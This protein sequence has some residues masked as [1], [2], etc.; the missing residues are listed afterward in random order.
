MSQLFSG[1][2][3]L[4]NTYLRI[5]TL[6]LKGV[7]R[8]VFLVRFGVPRERWHR[9]GNN[10]GYGEEHHRELALQFSHLPTSIWAQWP[11][12]SGPRNRKHSEIEAVTRSLGSKCLGGA[13]EPHACLVDDTLQENRGLT[14]ASPDSPTYLSYFVPKS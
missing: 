10:E 11:R 6:A 14:Q 9:G 2:L 8:A 13:Y 4:E 3:I 12:T 1:S 7:R 5:D